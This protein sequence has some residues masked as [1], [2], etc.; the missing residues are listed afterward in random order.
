MFLANRKCL[1]FHIFRMSTLTFEHFQNT[2]FSGIVTMFPGCFEPL[3]KVIKKET[4]M[5]SLTYTM[6]TSKIYS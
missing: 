4:K 3:P 6:S 5:R 2:F 1:H